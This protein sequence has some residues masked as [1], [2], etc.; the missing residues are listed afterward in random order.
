MSVLI[1]EPPKKRKSS[2]TESK[3]G[4]SKDLIFGYKY[5]STVLQSRGSKKK[6]PAEPLSNDEETIKRLKVSLQLIAI[7][8]FS[9]CTVF[10]RRV[11]HKKSM[12]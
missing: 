8:L 7:F 11:W 5:S 10:S 2:K 4:V 9:T 3:P 6:K 1:D 12:V